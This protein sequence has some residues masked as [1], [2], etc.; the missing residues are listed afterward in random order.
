[1]GS[2]CA[3]SNSGYING[4]IIDAQMR[5]Y[6]IRYVKEG[7]LSERDYNPTRLNVQTYEG[8]PMSILGYG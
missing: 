7:Q 4:I 3:K 2:F 1:M 5:G 6:T 8:K